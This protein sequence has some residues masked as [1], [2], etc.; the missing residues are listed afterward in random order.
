MGANYGGEDRL[1]MVDLK[2]IAAAAAEELQKAATGKAVRYVASEERCCNEVARV[3]G[4]AIGKPDL[5][6][7]TF[8]DAQMLQGLQNAGMPAHA[9]EMLVELGAAIHSG[10]MFREYD[11]NKPSL[12]KVKLADF[13]KEFA[14]AFNEQ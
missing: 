7:R 6:W 9:A 10:I 3:L 11:E 2:D 8:T 12:G 5:A 13:A 1:V 14:V 4:A